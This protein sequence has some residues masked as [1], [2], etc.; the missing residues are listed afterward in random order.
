MKLTAKLIFIFIAV[1]VVPLLAGGAF[2]LHSFE[3]FMV[4]MVP[5]ERVELA[6]TFVNEMQSR[7]ISFSGILLLP[8]AVISFLLSRNLTSPLREI[9]LTARKVARGDFKAKAKISSHDEFGEL[10]ENFNK[11]TEKLEKLKEDIEEEKNILE[12]KVKARTR[13]LEEMNETLEKQVEERTKEMKKKLE[14]LEKMRKLMVG[15]ELKMKEMKKE[16]ARLKEEKGEKGE[17][18]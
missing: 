13:E 18:S 10:A 2:L 6:E 9:S 5:A 3:S 7:Y 1:G 16:L 12:V 11:M 15:R 14:E 17:E 8:I 4:E